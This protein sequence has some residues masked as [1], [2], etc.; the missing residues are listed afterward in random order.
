MGVNSITWAPLSNSEDFSVFFYKCLL[1]LSKDEFNA[2][3]KFQ[4]KLATASCDNTVKI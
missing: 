1:F 2:E 3:Y 4:C